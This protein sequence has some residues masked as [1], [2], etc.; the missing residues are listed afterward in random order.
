LYEAK[1]SNKCRLHFTAALIPNFILTVYCISEY[2]QYMTAL[3]FVMFLILT[4]DL[5][6]RRVV[7]PVSCIF[8]ETI[9]IVQ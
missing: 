1:Y 3:C 9:C 6:G 7:S 5:I 2:A 4:C 8:I